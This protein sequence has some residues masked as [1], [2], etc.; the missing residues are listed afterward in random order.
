MRGSSEK[1]TPFLCINPASPLFSHPSLL[2]LLT[3]ATPQ[4]DPKQTG[5]WT[6]CVATQQQE[7]V[8]WARVSW[9]PSGRDPPPPPP[10]PWGDILRRICI[11]L[12]VFKKVLFVKTLLP[13]QSLSI[14]QLKAYKKYYD[15]IISYATHIS[16]WWTTCL[17][18]WH[19][20]MFPIVF[21]IYR[22]LH[23]KLHSGKQRL[24]H[25]PL[26]KR[27]SSFIHFVFKPLKRD[28]TR[29]SYRWKETP[30]AFFCQGKRFP[31]WGDRQHWV[32][33]SSVTVKVTF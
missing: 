20:T 31:C 6:W 11:I 9:S 10:L 21:F 22:H 4:P 15:I 13:V 12:T 3:Y 19:L 8:F 1:W 24:K 16:Y 32:E 29:P 28:H 5:Y 14:C 2:S 30:L 27:S 33:Q 26:I 25:C 7:N 23:C 17:I 18:K